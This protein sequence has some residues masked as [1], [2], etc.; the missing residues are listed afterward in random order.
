MR[1]PQC[2]C[3]CH[4]DRDTP[5]ITYHGVNI[6]LDVERTGGIETVTACQSCIDGHCSALLLTRLAN[7]PAPE[8]REKMPW[9]DQLAP[10]KPKQA[11]SDN[12]EGAE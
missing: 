12:G 7:D 9:I 8:R 6:P 2:L 10:D 3:L 5:L 1:F 4:W 11:D